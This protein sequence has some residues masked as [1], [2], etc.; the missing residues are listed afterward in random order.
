[1]PFGAVAGVRALNYS[2]VTI[3]LHSRPCIP[4]VIAC[5][6]EAQKCMC[7]TPGGMCVT[8]GGMCVT[9]GGMCV[10]PG[11]MCVTPGGRKGSVTGV[12]RH[13]QICAQ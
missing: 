11:G 1:M 8:P 12:L 9:P 13:I 4:A 2:V 10:T 5:V 3:S 6:C 7:V